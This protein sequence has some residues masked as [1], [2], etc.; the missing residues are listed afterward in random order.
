MHTSVAHKEMHTGELPRLAD[1]PGL[2]GS[3]SWLWLGLATGLLLISSG[4]NNVPLAA[5]LAPVFLLRFVRR[6]QAWFGLPV[7]YVVLVATMTFY[8]RGMVPIPGVGYYV[9]L[10]LWGMPMVAP[11]VVD[12]LVAH[13]LAGLL[14]TLVFPT[15]W[16][17]T[18]YLLTHGPYG[19]W[20][21]AAYSQYGNLALLQVVSVTGMW[22][23]TFLIGWFAAVCNWV[24]EDGL[25]SRRAR[26][27][28][29]LCAGT[30][31]T[32]MLLGGIRMA[33]FPPSSQ[34]VRVA[35]LSR[36]KVQPEP[37]D[38]TWQH[39]LANQATVSEVEEVRAGTV[40]ISNNLLARA[41]REAQASAKIVFWG[42]GNAPVMK[43]DEATL[44]ARGRE[45]AAKY[46]IYLGMAL[47]TW[48]QGKNPPLEN[49][50]VLIKPDGQV[51]WEYNKA[52]PVPG[53]EA[54]MQIRGD[55]KLRALDTQFGRLSSII[56]FDGDF[57]QLLAQAGALGADVVLDPSNDWRAID[58]WHTQMAS[59][60]AIEQGVNLIRHTSQGLSAAFD[61]QGRRLAAMDH[62]QTSDYV[63][64]SEVPT[65]GVR[66]VYSRLGDWF[67]WVCVAALLLLV[68]KAVMSH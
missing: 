11:Y 42:E 30:I 18:E 62:Y 20:G 24:W 19:S 1:R 15:A 47:A 2:S 28:A 5:W 7:A 16:V 37:S 31:V 38:T 27:G 58:P 50:L 26:G 41:E 45:L 40:A 48:H 9:F 60:R 65:K 8:F 67:A 14:T 34:T 13:R 49:K 54:A 44:I 3:R 63:M 6:Q 56:C 59:F 32:V 35:S 33:L 53:G 39:L 64:I 36:M 52:R 25:D 29:W 43:E 68:G 66:T 23:I 46:Q 22:G 21:A 4:A 55:G 57:P 10:V 51:S 17:V 61:Y 12:R